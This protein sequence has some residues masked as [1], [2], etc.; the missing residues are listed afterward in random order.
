MLYDRGFFLN[1]CY[2]ELNLKGPDAVRSV[3]EAY[4]RA[5][6]EIVETNTFGA[7]PV[8]LSGFGLEDRTE[9][10]NRRAA[11][12]ARAAAGERVSV[13]GAIGPL[14]IRIEPFGPTSREE[15]S[16]YF[17]RQ[18]GGLLEGGV[19]G[20]VLETFSD[21]GELNAAYD[22]LREIA[23]LPVITQM[24]VGAEGK[25]SYGSDVEAITTAIDEWKPDVIGLNCSVG[26]SAMFESIKRMA[27]LTE[28][29]ISAL[30][31]AGLPKTVSGRKMYLASPEYMA[32][33]AK[34]FIDAG[35]RFVGGCCGTTPEH[36]KKVRDMVAGMQP[37]KVQVFVSH[38]GEDPVPLA[39]RSN[40]GR[41]IAAGEFVSSV[42]IT[43]P[44]G[45]DP[46]EMIEGCRAVKEAGI[47][48]VNILDAP[49]AQGLMASVPSSVIIQRE[50]GIE[51]VF[52]YTC[53]DRNMT[54]MISDLLGA[55]A[56]GLRNILII[57]GDPP[58]MG[59]YQDSTTVFDI[60]SIGLTN[61]VAR[62]NRGLDP[63]GNPIDSPT[64]FVIG[65][66]ANPGAVDQERE[67]KR[68]YW[69]VDAG[70]E[71]AITQPIFDPDSLEAFLERIQDYRVPIIAGLWPLVSD[72]NAEFLANEVPGVVVPKRVLKRM[73][74]AQ[75]R[76]DEAAVAE[77]VEVVREV[78]ERIRGWIQ[79]VYI[80][81]PE[82][83][84]DAALRVLE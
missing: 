25:T 40:W 69:K 78:L 9:E 73:H 47:D 33:Y 72:R 70:A 43:P 27:T 26:P 21:L 44:G 12:I 57:T 18:A 80:A 14:G 71:F 79:G 19:D 51:T 55:A 84:V 50:V 60:D 58:A 29:P 38:G 59:P 30:P 56:T 36:I 4:I 75:A 64:R 28:R 17:A 10:I 67:Q 68:L 74:A 37:R 20:F 45:P 62:L 63:G 3:H 34:R 11:E 52:H 83:R 61:L 82:G 76:G 1:V 6:A 32:R 46:R 22:A 5:G 15:A 7:N 41:K 24:T 23:D 48:A 54:R 35:A 13:V 16:E 81:A 66:A 39:E 31:N 2:D 42:E 53:R 77:G 49:R 8:K 65:V